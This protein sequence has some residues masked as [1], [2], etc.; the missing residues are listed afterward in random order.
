MMTP[1]FL[2]QRARL[3]KYKAEEAWYL[4]TVPVEESGLAECD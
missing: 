4:Q 3:A 2:I 1:I